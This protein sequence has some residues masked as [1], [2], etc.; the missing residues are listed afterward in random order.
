MD[1]AHYNRAVAELNG[2]IYL[3]GGGTYLNQSLLVERYDPVKDEWMKVAKMKYP[4]YDFG[5]IELGGFLYAVG[6]NSNH[7]NIERYN[8]EQNDWVRLRRA[9][10]LEVFLFHFPHIPEC[11]A[12]RYIRR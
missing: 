9:G 10:D 5:L 7:A 1:V 11:F 3:A 8:S 4:R 12:F 2:Y 6:G